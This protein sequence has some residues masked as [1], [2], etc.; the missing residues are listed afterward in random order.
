METTTSTTP[1]MALPVK[2]PLSVHI[3]KSNSH[4][5]GSAVPVG[6]MPRS[7]QIRYERIWQNESAFL[8]EEK[9]AEPAFAQTTKSSDCDNDTKG[10][11]E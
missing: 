5:I 4:S 9:V 2:K 3:P 10:I 7:Q 6:E 8:N 1:D 11:N